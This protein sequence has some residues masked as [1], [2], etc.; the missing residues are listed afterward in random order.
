MSRKGIVSREVVKMK[1]QRSSSSQSRY[2][3]RHSLVAAGWDDMRRYNPLL[4]VRRVHADLVSSSR[5]VVALIS[6]EVEIGR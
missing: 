2:R 4:R 1:S 3:S 6:V 5:S